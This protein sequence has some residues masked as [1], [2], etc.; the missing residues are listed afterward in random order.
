MG[1]YE[2]FGHH[3]PD[4]VERRTTT[5]RALREGACPGAL[6]TVPALTRVPRVRQTLTLSDAGCRHPDGGAGHLEQVVIGTLRDGCDGVGDARGPDPGRS[7][8]PGRCRSLG[9]LAPFLGSGSPACRTIVQAEPTERPFCP[10]ERVATAEP[11]GSGHLA[12][13]PRG[14]P[15]A[16]QR[17]RRHQPGGHVENQDLP[18]KLSS[19]FP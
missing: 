10:E 1:S 8:V 7:R 19:T 18:Q 4:T 5:A 3:P 2:R 6:R 14:A 9:P 12:G 15:G 13:R 11:S 17:R 16:A